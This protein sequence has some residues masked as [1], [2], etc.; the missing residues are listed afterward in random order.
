MKKILVLGLTA[1]LSISLCA[2]SKAEETFE[3]PYRPVSYLN[4]YFQDGRLTG[5]DLSEYIYSENGLLIQSLLY[6]DGILASTNTNEYD[7]F[8]NLLRCTS[9]SG[10]KTIIYENKLTLD[11]QGRILRQEDYKDGVL[12]STLEYSYNKKGNVM[13]EIYTVLKVGKTDHVRHREMTY[14]RTGQLIREI[15]RNIDGSYIRYDYEDGRE[16]KASNYDASDELT[17]YW[18]SVYDEEGK[19]AQKSSYTCKQNTPDTRTSILNSYYLYTYD[20]SGLVVTMTCYNA[21]GTRVPTE[22][23][24]VSTY[25]EYGNQLL[26]E[27]YM[28]GELCWRI[29]QTFEPIP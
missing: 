22:R 3:N 21:D 13:S 12:C 24:T 29:T 5:S 23:H 26:H 7:E 8:G 11:D 19:L 16:V 4:E 10:E 1:L 6:K 18:E 28:G 15:L 9:E 25:D 14:D 27:R 20:E 2:C 17:G